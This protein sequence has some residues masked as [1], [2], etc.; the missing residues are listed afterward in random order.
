MDGTL[1]KELS[2]VIMGE[3]QT[4]QTELSIHVA[5]PNAKPPPCFTE[6]SHQV[7]F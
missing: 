6:V 3:N 4:T 7:Y 2:L 5:I 1:G